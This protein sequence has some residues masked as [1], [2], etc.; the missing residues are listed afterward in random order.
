MIESSQLEVCTRCKAQTHNKRLRVR[1]R[2]AIKLFIQ[3]DINIG[4]AG[5]VRSG[6]G[7]WW[8]CGKQIIMLLPGL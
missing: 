2:V 5:E 1:V 7:S 6:S 3:Q 4:H 8:R